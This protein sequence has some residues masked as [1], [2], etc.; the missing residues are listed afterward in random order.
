M[1]KWENI[2]LL[3]VEDDELA[4]ENAV[5]F[6]SDYFSVIYEAK[7][8]LEA[9]DLYTKYSPD[10]IITDIQMPKINGL[11]F[12]RKIRTEDKRT[13]V[14]IT[15]AFSTKEYLL[16]AIELQLVKYLIKPIVQKDLE[17]ALHICVNTLKDDKS[18]IIKIDDDHSFDIFNKTLFC[19]NELV[20]LRIKELLFL[21]LLIKNQDR[22]VPYQEIENIVWQDNV[23]TKD[24]LKSLV[25]RVKSY[26]ITPCIKNLSG[27]GYKIDL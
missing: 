9:L 11:E 14:I 3:Y 23:M 26:F 15:T 25:K 8:G 2:K 22:F 12:V 19:K 24:A 6:L 5:E 18:N 21:E 27:V 13:Q 17:E 7:D 4:R 20:K 1:N 16:G 10:I